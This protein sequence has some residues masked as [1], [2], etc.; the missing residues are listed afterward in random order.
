MK[1]V[2]SNIVPYIIIIIV[3]ILIRIY[4]ITPEIV[5]GES[6]ENT[7]YDGEWLLNSKI[8]YKL[9]DIK[10]FDIVIIKKKD[11]LIIKR[12]IGLPGEYIEYKDNNLYVNGILVS[13]NYMK[14]DTNNFTLN[15]ICYDCEVIPEGKY[16]VLGDN[17]EVSADSRSKDLGL[18]DIED[19]TG[20]AVFRIWPLSRLGIID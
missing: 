3:V 15:D 1:K 14:E 17:R 10:R 19:I 16:L 12:I 13:D 9:T 2:L 11:Y 4:I 20:K 18:V 6:M 5:S 7:L 8:S